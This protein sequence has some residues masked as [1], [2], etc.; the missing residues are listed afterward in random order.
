MQTMGKCRSLAI[1]SFSP[2]LCRHVKKF[3]PKRAK[4]TSHTMIQMDSPVSPH[5]AA[6]ESPTVCPFD[7]KVTMED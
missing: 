1:S 6:L 4:I 3:T 5:L 7:T 2:F